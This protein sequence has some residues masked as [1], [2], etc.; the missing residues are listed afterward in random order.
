MLETIAIFVGI[1]ALIYGGIAALTL[2]PGRKAEKARV[3]NGEWEFSP[4]LWAG[5]TAI[6]VP[7]EESLAGTAVGGARGTW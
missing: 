5:D 2:L 3:A 4:Q 7:S 1:P 6:A